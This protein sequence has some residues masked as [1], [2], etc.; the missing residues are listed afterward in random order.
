MT[1]LGRRTRSRARLFFERFL[2]AHFL[3]YPVAFVASI[4]A[5][6][7]AVRLRAAALLNAGSEGASSRIMRDVAQQ[8][9]LSPTEAAQAEI[10]FTFVLWT[11]IAVLLVVHLASLPWAIAAARAASHVPP[12]ERGVRRG[13]N[14][15]VGV[16]IA[17]VILVVLC[18]AVGWL[19]LL[20]L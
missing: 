5:M 14:V 2:L 20:L 16:T 11:C 18:G 17:T 15:F 6:P 19:W 12:D 8:L 10:V 13:R 9:E 4:A 3:S 1:A 7:M